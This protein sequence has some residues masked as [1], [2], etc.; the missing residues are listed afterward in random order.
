MIIAMFSWSQKIFILLHGSY[1]ITLMYMC[2]NYSRVL[3]V[4]LTRET[5]IHTNPTLYCL[6]FNRRRFYKGM[7]NPDRVKSVHP[8][9]QCG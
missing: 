3:A 9:V 2:I 4:Y 8:F 1:H 7:T 5:P 6:G